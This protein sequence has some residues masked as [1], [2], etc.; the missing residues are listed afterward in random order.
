MTP[1][2]IERREYEYE[3]HGTQALIAA[4]NVATSQVQGIVGSTHR[5]NDLCFHETLFAFGGAQPH[6]I[7][8]ASI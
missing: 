3:R 4:F 2:R 8:C 6:G 1:H 7:G 5:E